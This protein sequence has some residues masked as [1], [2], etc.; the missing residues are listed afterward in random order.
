MTT[1]LKDRWRY[2]NAPEAGALTLAEHDKIEAACTAWRSLKETIKR[3]FELWIT[4]GQGL[5]TLRNKADHLGGRSTFERLRNQAGLGEIDKGTVSRLLQIMERLPEVTRW[6][7]QLPE[8]QQVE[9]ASPSALFKHCP[10]VAKP[11]IADAEKRLSPMEKLREANIALQAENHSL[12]QREDGDRWKPT[13][14]AHDIAVAMVGI[15][16]TTKAEQVARNILEL[17][18]RRRVK[19]TRPMAAN[20]EA[21]A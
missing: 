14:T 4:I 13:D 20:T 9:W 2:H 1:E 19:R 7:D 18:E 11:K 3:T 15:L 8:Y 21:E 12:K 17:L 5:Q 16:T 10:I 6:H